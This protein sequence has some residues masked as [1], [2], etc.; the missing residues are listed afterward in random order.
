[1]RYYSIDLHGQFPNLVVGSPIL[2]TK[3]DSPNTVIVVTALFDDPPPIKAEIYCNSMKTWESN[4]SG[5]ETF[6]KGVGGPDFKRLGKLAY[7][8]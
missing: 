6:E 1:M 2:G 7:R 8:P 4:M 5:A 3:S